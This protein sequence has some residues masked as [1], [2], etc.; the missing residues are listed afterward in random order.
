V[1]I[2]LAHDLCVVLHLSIHGC[3]CSLFL[4]D[5]VLV[6]SET[7]KSTASRIVVATG[8]VEVSEVELHCKC[9][10]QLDLLNIL[11]HLQFVVTLSHC[12]LGLR[13]VL[14]EDYNDFVNGRLWIQLLKNGLHGFDEQIDIE[15]LLWSRDR[16]RLMHLDLFM[17]QAAITYRC[18]GR[19]SSARVTLNTMQPIL[20]IL[21][22]NLIH[23][24]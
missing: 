10:G 19:T 9:H 24:W 16:R 6:T 7:D 21:S 17:L 5:K 3:Q 13:N 4:C 2:V 15:R 23:M 14:L 18:C 8:I 11:N 20:R 12:F 22:D 1:V